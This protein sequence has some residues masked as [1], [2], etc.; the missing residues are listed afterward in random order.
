[1]F[2]VDRVWHTDPGARLHVDDGFGNRNA[3]VVL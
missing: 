3:V 1:M 2:V